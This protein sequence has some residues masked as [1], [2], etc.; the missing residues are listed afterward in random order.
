[1]TDG[2][3][4]LVVGL[5]ESGEAAALLAHAEGANVTV[6][7]TRETDGLRA[8]ARALDLLGIR[9]VLGCADPAS[10]GRFDEAVISPGLPLGSPAI[11]GLA[12]AGLS[13]VPE[14]E[15]AAR[16]FEGTILAI[17]GSNGKSTMCQWCHDALVAAGRR[18]GLGGNFGPAAS[19]VIL[20]D[21]HELDWL[22]L[23]LSSFQLEAAR[24]FRPRGA[25]LLNLLPNHLDRHGSMDGYRAAKARLF[26][27]MEEGDVAAAPADLLD[28][29]A[30][31]GPVGRI[32]T[33]PGGD[34]VWSGGSVRSRDGEVLAD[35]SGTPLDNPV[36]GANAVGPAAVL[37]RLGVPAEALRRAAEAFQPLPHRLQPLGAWR[38]IRFVNDSKSTNAA[39]LGA[40]L[41]AMDA[42]VRLLAGGRAKPEDFSGLA[43]ALRARAASIHL[44]GESQDLLAAAWAGTGVPVS[45]APDLEA[46]FAQAVAA[47]GSGEIVL[48][49]PGCVSYDQFQNF[50]RRGDAFVSLTRRLTQEGRQP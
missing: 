7:D 21:G 24:A 45:R 11:R 39:A 28:R 47:A 36:H 48:F 46:A 37:R 3:D 27:A 23:E 5:G 32:A 34:A 35:L 44:F 8:R 10:L 19:R 38:G 26:Q 30:I 16:C 6:A 14:F 20:A 33:G 43:P 31:P 4:I 29:L 40:A 18:T 41:A 25:V 12:E 22:V 15:F 1:M 13:V 42:P 50:E 49:S 17:T 9:T 2:A